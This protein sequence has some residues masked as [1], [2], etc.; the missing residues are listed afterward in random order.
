MSP[1]RRRQNEV[2]I[3]K[4]GLLGKGKLSRMLFFLANAMTIKVWRSAN[5]I[6]R[7]IIVI[8][9]APNCAMYL[10]GL[11]GWASRGSH[12]M[13]LLMLRFSLLY[14]KYFRDR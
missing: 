11:L 13:T 9:Q 4:R 10:R 3:L 14:L 8:A 5:W 1:K 12:R 2:F 6:L 7:N